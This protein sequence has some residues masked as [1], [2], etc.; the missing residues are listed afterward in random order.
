[1]RGIT[2]DSTQETRGHKEMGFNEGK[3]QSWKQQGKDSLAVEEGSVDTATQTSFCETAM[4][5][6]T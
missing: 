3:Q 5:L 1:M 6:L 2:T 4:L